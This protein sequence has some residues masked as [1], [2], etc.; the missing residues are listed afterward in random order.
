MGDKRPKLDENILAYYESREAEGERLVQGLGKL[1]FL[2]VQELVRRHLPDRSLRILD[3]GGAA[4]IHASWLAAD[5]H[6]VQ[7]VDPVPVHIEQAS[8]AASDLDRSFTAALG[9]ARDLPVDDGSVDVVLMFGPLYHL[10]DEVDRLRALAEARRILVPGG[11]LFAIGISRFASLFD[12]LANG[13][14]FDPE[15][16]QIA[17]REV[18][19]G[20]HRNPTSRRGWFATAFFHHPDQLEA[21]IGGAGFDVLALYGVQG[22][23][24]WLRPL[25]ER[26]DDPDDL[27]IVLESAR[28]VESEPSLRCLSPHMLVVAER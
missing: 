11:L 17:E 22:M 16:R 19:D 15:F 10:V 9:D 3:V 14:L 28:A 27:E 18:V 8:R 5:G 21:E 2:R 24:G 23:A 26:L 20:Q 12:G 1:E 25:A 7:I 13:M 6:T 4:G